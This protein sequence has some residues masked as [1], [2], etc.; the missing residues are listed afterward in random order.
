VTPESGDASTRG[1][2]RVERGRKRVRAYLGGTLVADTLTPWLVWELPYYP[3]YYLPRAD[4][5]AELIETGR[6]EHSPSRG[7]GHVHDLK[8]GAA[9]AEAAAVVFP[10]SPLPELRDLVRIRW[11]AMDDWLEEDEIV[12]THPRDP[13]TRVDILDSSRRVQVLV[14][15]VEVADSDQP[16]ILFETGLPP[17]YYLPFAHVR[18]DLLRPSASVSH[19][20]YKG[21]A[22]YWSVEV[23]GT[24]HR[25]LVWT[26]RTPRP[27]STK[28]AGMLS[29]YNEKVDLLVDGVPQDRPRTHFS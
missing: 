14:D 29:F 24:L 17:R 16:R 7:T 23:A 5:A 9:V 19:C 27:E 20:P 18:T 15:G 28:I 13:Y 25:D 12:Y 8:A 2:V 22:S 21:Q 3:T 4:V 11:D 10:E 6:T 26:Y 1:R